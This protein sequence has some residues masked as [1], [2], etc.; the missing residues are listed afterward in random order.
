MKYPQRLFL[1]ALSA[2][3]LVLH[4]C[5]CSSS[6]S[7]IDSGT[8]TP[9]FQLSGMA[10]KGI[11]INANVNAYSF[12]GGAL[13]ADPVASG[14]TNNQGGYSLSVPRT[15][16]NAPMLIVV[17]ASPDGTFMRCDLTYGCGEGVDFGD[18]VLIGADEEFLLESFIS[19]ATAYQP[20]NVTLLTHLAAQQVKTNG[21]PT[22]MTALRQAIAQANSRVANRFGITGN[23][24]SAPIID[25]TNAAAVNAALSNHSQAIHIAAINAALVQAQRYK[26]PGSSIAS[27]ATNFALTYVQQNG[28]AGN[29]TSTTMPGYNEILQAAQ[30]ILVRV[31]T[32]TPGAPI[33]LAALLAELAAQEQLAANEPPDTYN[34]GTPSETGDQPPLD[35]VKAMVADLRDLSLSIGGAT[36]EGGE[37]LRS[38]AEEFHLQ[39]HAA[40]MATSVDMHYLIDALAKTAEAVEEADRAYRGDATTTSYEHGDILVHIETTDGVPHYSVNQDV[41]VE[42]E[43]STAWVTTNVSTNWVLNTES[44]VD[45]GDESMSGSGTANLTGSLE[46]ENLRL[47][48][49]QD[50]HI[51]LAVNASLVEDEAVHTQVDVD[52]VH[53]NLNVTIEEPLED[54]PVSLSAHIALQIAA[55]TG[56]ELE[57]TTETSIRVLPSTLSLRVSGEVSNQV[58]DAYRFA[59]AAAGDARGTVFEDGNLQES[60][61][62][63]AEFTASL[64]FNATLAG[65]PDVVVVSYNLVRTGLDSGQ[66]TLVLRYFPGKLLRL[67]AAVVDGDLTR[68]VTVTNQDGV[69]L[70]LMETEDANGQSQIE[71]NIT[72][73]GTVYATIEQSS[74][75]V[76]I[77]RYS[78]ETFES[79]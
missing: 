70:T 44:T 66:N 25:L 6:R 14:A 61:T 28:L 15:H 29:T 11:L 41:A 35:Q 32:L 31:Q 65:V 9:T 22:E 23:L 60:A 21:L 7:R 40:E 33:N 5:S 27:A 55:F 77:I 37:T 56:E 46:T 72:L 62:E 36:L 57:S 48:L 59:F 3:A 75:A 30:N 20:A 78:D 79:I 8:P 64:I 12:Q 16:Q 49:H 54:N 1:L 74:S 63:F 51:T 19:S 53:M 34:P 69:V 47:T 43:G 68:A 39:L 76:I 42:H 4:G 26:N 2:A 50:S 24:T 10:S 52:M 71:G 17:T 73:D 45:D 18:D 67:E 38:A 58:G 13:H